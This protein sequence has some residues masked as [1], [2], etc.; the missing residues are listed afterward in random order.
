VFGASA[1]KVSYNQEFSDDKGYPFPL[2]SDPDLKLIKDLGIVL[3]GKLSK[4]V[5]FVIG[6]DG[7]IA[8]VYETVKPATHAK[9]VLEFVKG[10]K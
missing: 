1:D 4:R 8:K 3:N 7:K 6:K 10:L 2:I 5:T 9:E